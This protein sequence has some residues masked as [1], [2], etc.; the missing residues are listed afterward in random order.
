[1]TVSNSVKH[2][3]VFG[4]QWGDEGKGKIVDLLTR[5]HD[6]VVRYN[7][8]ANAGH[9]VEIGDQRYALHLL[10]SGILSPGKLNVIGNGVVLDPMQLVTE[11][12]SMTS[13][14]ID[15]SD[16]LRISNRAHLVMPYHKQQD[17]L[18][19]AAVSASR[20][21]HKM[22]GTTGRGIGPAYSDKMLRSVGIRAGDLLDADRF[23]DKVRHI[24]HVKNA[25]L[26]AL[27]TMAGQ[28]WQVLDD[29]QI[30]DDYL[31]A[32]EKIGSFICD[33]TALLHGAM[34][35]GKRLLFEGA[36]G[37]MLDIDHGT[38]PYVTSSNPGS[39][40]I[41]AGAGVPGG[42][43]GRV[44][45]IMKS[46][47]TRVGAGPFATELK[48]EVGDR[49][50][51][52]GN[53]FGTTTGRPRRCGWP[54]LA[55]VKYTAQVNG[56]TELAVMLLDVLAGFNPLKVCVG[57][58]RN[59]KKLNAFP[60]DAAALTGV[61]PIYETLDGFTD[62]ITECENYDELPTGAKA[63]IELVEQ[64]VGVPVSIVSVGPRRS[65]TIHRND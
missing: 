12:E 35:D 62:E 13:R 10:P 24:C 9:S 30:A 44:V 5:E 14:D 42:T 7:G 19:E 59:G 49:I 37:T 18:L 43:V 16:N 47:T 58:K 63:Y 25:M 65:Q 2:T 21:D 4:L 3:A 54:D 31:A 11:M 34:A 40:G 27:A 46:Y 41:Y 22:I 64:T 39:I 23:R 20:G 32:A 28:P 17:A 52:R 56:V 29:Q 36:N 26:G 55:V 53:E 1:M 50:R 6:V 8:G 57:Y 15:M 51:N 38:Y 61:E 33:T 60:H 45:G 48:D